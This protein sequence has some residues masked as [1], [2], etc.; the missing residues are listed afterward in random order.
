MSDPKF[1]AYEILDIKAPDGETEE[2]K[3]TWRY[4]GHMI[5]GNVGCCINCGLPDDDDLPD[6]CPGGIT[7]ERRDEIARAME[8]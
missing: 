6:E 2:A 1:V 4:S 5:L 8:P 7:Q 3:Y